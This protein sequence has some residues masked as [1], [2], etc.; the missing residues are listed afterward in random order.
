M[1]KTSA[2][3]IDRQQL[4]FSNVRIPRSKKILA[5]ARPWVWREVKMTKGTTVSHQ[6]GKLSQNEA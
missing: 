4:V 3:S 1:N 2:V 5:L 6:K